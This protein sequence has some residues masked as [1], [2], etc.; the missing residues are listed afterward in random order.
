MIAMQ[1]IKIFKGVESETGA[2]EAEVNRWLAESNARVINMF[3]NIAP[4]SQSTA[5]SGTLSTSVFAASD[6]FLV[7]LY[8][9]ES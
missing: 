9:K 1:Q 3:G 2:L 5:Q 6:V 4:Q 7:I 8:E